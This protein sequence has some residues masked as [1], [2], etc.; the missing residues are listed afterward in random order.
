M[1]TKKK[2]QKNKVSKKKEIIKKLVKAVTKKKEIPVIKKQVVKEQDF[3]R[4]EKI[5]GFMKIN[6]LRFQCSCP[7]CKTYINIEFNSPVCPACKE[8]L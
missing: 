5:D 1:M 2:V 7:K 8:K 4:F 6:N 3:S